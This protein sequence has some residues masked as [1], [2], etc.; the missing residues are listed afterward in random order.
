MPRIAGRTWIRCSRR[1]T[2]WRRSSARRRPSSLLAARAERSHQGTSVT[3]WWDQ[4]NSWFQEALL[5]AQPRLALHGRFTTLTAEWVVH[6]S[7]LARCLDALHIHPATPLGG[8]AWTAAGSSGPPPPWV[9][10]QWRP[11]RLALSTPPT[12][13][14]KG[15][16]L[17]P[18]IFPPLRRGRDVTRLALAVAG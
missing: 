2:S 9:G 10:G 5:S 8:S 6:L 3:R 14:R 17:P 7:F 11:V 16:Q 4:V 15:G 12:P 1:P 18:S 13:L